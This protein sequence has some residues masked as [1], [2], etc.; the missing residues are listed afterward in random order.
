MAASDVLGAG[1]F[2]AAWN[3]NER[4]HTMPDQ[5]V[6]ADGVVVGRTSAGR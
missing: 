1:W 2:A 3:L 5:Q 6:D 4:V